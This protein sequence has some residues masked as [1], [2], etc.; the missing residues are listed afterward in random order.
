MRIIQSAWSCDQE[1]ILNSNFGW[2][3]PE[4]NLVSWTLSCLQLRQFYPD[5]V[6]YCDSI[7]K[8]L[9]IDQ[10]QLPYNEVVCTLVLYFLLNFVQ[11][12]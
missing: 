5:V 3:A 7:Y 12:I 2:L 6:L 11:N 1:N 8:E 10:L 4:Y 9:L